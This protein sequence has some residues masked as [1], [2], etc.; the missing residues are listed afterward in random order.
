MIDSEHLKEGITLNDFLQGVSS[1]LGI[2]AINNVR[3]LCYV[4]IAAQKM[5]DISQSIIG[6]AIED[7]DIADF[8]PGEEV[9]G[10]KE[11]PYRDKV[12]GLHV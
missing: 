8:W 1:H 3:E 5:L 10:G 7:I 11:F 2:L 6:K 9:L 4:N 12:F